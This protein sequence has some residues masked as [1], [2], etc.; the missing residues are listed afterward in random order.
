MKSVNTEDELNKELTNMLE[1]KKD[2]HC[3]L[4]LACVL[5]KNSTD[6]DIIKDIPNLRICNYLDPKMPKEAPKTEIND[7]LF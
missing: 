7:T 1:L 6:T 3:D 2:E 4:T 5:D